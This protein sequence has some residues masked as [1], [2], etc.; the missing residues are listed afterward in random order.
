MF[1]REGPT[2]RDSE[3]LSPGG[4]LVSMHAGPSDYCISLAA[5][6]GLPS[7]VLIVPLKK[8]IQIM[9]CLIY[10]TGHDLLQ[11]KKWGEKTK[12]PNATFYCEG[13]NYNKPRTHTVVAKTENYFH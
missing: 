7:C 8:K 10:D 6:A 4:S 9:D 13:A 2:G 1:E 11:A 5:I 12:K 3:S